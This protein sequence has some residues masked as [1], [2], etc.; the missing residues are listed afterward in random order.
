MPVSQLQ[1]H[2]SYSCSS[3]PRPLLPLRC[4]SWSVSPSNNNKAIGYIKTLNAMNTP[5]DKQCVLVCCLLFVWLESMSGRYA[6][7]IR[8]F[9]AGTQLLANLQFQHD[10]ELN[11]ADELADICA[12]FGIGI[13]IFMEEAIM[14]RK[15]KLWCAIADGSWADG[16][17]Y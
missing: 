4:R 15:P 3:P 7:S 6:E 5:C 2:I 11:I 16:P 1:Q 17:F 8:H 9:K 10:A 13:S 12:R 14:P